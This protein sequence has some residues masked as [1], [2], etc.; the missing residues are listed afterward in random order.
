MQLLVY[1]TQASLD[2]PFGKEA[3]DEYGCLH[4]Y[5]R[6]VVYLKQSSLP[7]VLQ[8]EIKILFNPS[9]Q[10]MLQPKYMP[11]SNHTMLDFQGPTMAFVN[12][13]EKCSP[14]ML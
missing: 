10:V 7:L 3:F 13:F 12:L 2:I 9:V 5:P 6:R 4:D 8:K 14:F 1:K 11:T